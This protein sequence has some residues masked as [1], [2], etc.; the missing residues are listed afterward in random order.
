MAPVSRA[1]APRRAL[2]WRPGA[3]PACRRG[4]GAAPRHARCSCRGPPRGPRPPP[5]PAP[6]AAQVLPGPVPR[7]ARERTRASPAAP[8]CLRR[9]LCA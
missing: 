3:A 9:P 5:W 1:Q 7:V 2:P 4:S 8:A 6:R